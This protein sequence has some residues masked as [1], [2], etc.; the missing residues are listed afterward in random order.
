IRNCLGLILFSVN[1]GTVIFIFSFQYLK[2]AFIPAPGNF[3]VFQGLFYGTMRLVYMQ[4]IVKP[5]LSFSGKK[6]GKIIA[7]L[8][9]FHIYDTKPLNSRGVYNPGIET[10]IEHFGKRRG[11]LSLLMLSGNFG[12]FQVQPWFNSIDQG[13]FTYTGMPGK[14]AYFS[15]HPLFYL[16]YVF[17]V[18]G[19][20]AYTFVTYLAVHGR[21]IFYFQEFFLIVLIGFIEKQYG[22]DVICL[23]RNKK[24]VDKSG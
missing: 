20:Y 16:I 19:R 8:F 11:M 15:L 9:F 14:H 22:F 18:Q 24:T 6:L 7:Y 5:A 21:K 4:A 13:G 12:G 23:G 17:P 2:V 10:E 1:V 3:T